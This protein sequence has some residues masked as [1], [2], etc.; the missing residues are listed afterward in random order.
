M[1]AEHAVEVL[2]EVSIKPYI[3]NTFVTRSKT[4][5]AKHIPVCATSAVFICIAV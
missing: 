3:A 2:C 1:Y 5:I 4:Y